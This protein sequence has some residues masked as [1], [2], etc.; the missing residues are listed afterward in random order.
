M[1]TNDD[2]V[3]IKCSAQEEAWRTLEERRRRQEEYNTTL[4]QVRSPRVGETSS[5][6]T[7]NKKNKTTLLDLD[8]EEPKNL[9]MTT[10]TSLPQQ[11]L[12]PKPSQPTITLPFHDA[13]T[14]LNPDTFETH[15]FLS[16]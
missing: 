13:K 12:S 9:V 6:I 15:Y 14:V 5:M 4:S 7:Q 10:S 11:A 2:G 8:F 1:C 16:D 3:L